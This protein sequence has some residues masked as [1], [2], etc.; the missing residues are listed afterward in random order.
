[1]SRTRHF[2]LVGLLILMGGLLFSCRLAF[3]P[4]RVISAQI[5]GTIEQA[6]SVAAVRQSLE[7]RYKVITSG[8][9][10]GYFNM[11]SFFT[12]PDPNLVFFHVVAGQYWF[13]T[14]EAQVVTDKNGALRDITIRRTTDAP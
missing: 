9:G 7:R 8:S 2:A 6:R 1:M 10:A 14:V 4:D 12:K 5:R 3:T 11:G 13:T